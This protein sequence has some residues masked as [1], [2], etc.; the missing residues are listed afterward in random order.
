V[1]D[2]Q[3]V[4]TL[5]REFG[6]AANVIEKDYAL[7]WMLAGIAAHPELGPTWIFK[8]GTCL[9]KCY[10]ETYRFSEDLDF[11]LIDPGHLNE[12]FLLARFREV[13]EWI[14]DHTGIEIPAE[15][16]R[17]EV[18]QNPRGKASAQGRLGYRG[19]MRRAGDAPRIK[20]DLTDDEV[21]VLEPTLR[22][23]HHP[24]SDRSPE[25]I[26]VR[27]YGF[28]EV[29]AEKIRALAERE[30]P[31]DLYDVIHLF[32]HDELRPVREIVFTTLDQKCR[33]KGIPVPTMATVEQGPGRVELES[34][35]ETMLGHQL[36]ALPPFAQFWA[37]LPAVFEWL[38]GRAE[39]VVRRALQMAVPNVDEAWRPPAMSHVWGTVAPMEIIRF[40]AANRLC[41]D[42]QYQNSHRLIEPYSLRKTRDNNL[43]LYAV[44]HATGEP[45]SYRVD[46]IQGASAT[47]TSFTP[48]YLVELTPVGLLSA[49]P[50]ARIGE[51]PRPFSLGRPAGAR[52]VARRT[53]LGAGLKYVFECP[54][55]GK[56]FVRG[57][58]SA[59][60]NAHKDK[61][62]YPCPGRSGIYV[63]TKH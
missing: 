46:R 54:V 30:R 21:L 37:D 9:K 36:P 47:T 38:H 1:I 12:P 39:K 22:E 18:Y 4:M 3:E 48:R 6:L 61:Q 34:E 40:A 56:R 43:L 5:A 16:I 41:V 35:W 26:H 60:L 7:G 28:E 20:L 33:F 10:F 2:R 23:V 50:T 17:F 13:A 24:Y 15:T 53:G 42:L 27:C 8:G 62:G 25:G 49:P 51:Q 29:F 57:S 32:R 59:T 19:P 55:C 63:E 44:K 52:P 58:Y 31:R 45:R 14:Y 11:T